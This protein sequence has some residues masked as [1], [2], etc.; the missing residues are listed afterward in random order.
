MFLSYTLYL[1][2]SLFSLLD[3]RRSKRREE[4]LILPPQKPLSPSYLKHYYF[5]GNDRAVFKEK[6]HVPKRIDMFFRDLN[7]NH[8]K[9][10]RNIIYQTIHTN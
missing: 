1:H 10:I 3:F 5:Y 6:G 9:L 2:L 8:S 7:K 4:C